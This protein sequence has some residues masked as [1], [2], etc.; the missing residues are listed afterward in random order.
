[1]NTEG[2]GLVI[3]ALIALGAV[4]AFILVIGPPT[5][6]Y[7]GIGTSTMKIRDAFEACNRGSNCP[8]RMKPYPIHWDDYSQTVVCQ[9]PA[10]TGGYRPY[11]P[12]T[13]QRSLY[14]PG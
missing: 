1:M 8:H 9:C 6:E 13:F 2:I 11:E 3:F 5:G 7:S 4:F 14:Q 10:Q 12:F